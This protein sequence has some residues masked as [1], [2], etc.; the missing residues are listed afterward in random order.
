MLILGIHNITCDTMILN[1]SLRQPDQHTNMKAC[2]V[3][4]TY[5]EILIYETKGCWRRSLTMRGGSDSLLS[6]N[7]VS[8]LL[9]SFQTL[10]F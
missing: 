7:F 8:L 4:Y 9:L 1:L 5:I 3:T 10:G 2:T 6:V